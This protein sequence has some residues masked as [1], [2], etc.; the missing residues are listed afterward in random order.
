[1]KYISTRGQMEP[2]HFKE[3][4]LTGLA[5]DG[6]LVL[7]MDLPDISE[8][9]DEWKKLSYT[10]LAYEVI[11]LFATDIPAEDLRELVDRSY[12]SFTH[13]DVTPSVSVGDLHILELFH[14][15]TLAFK[16]VALQLLGNLFSYILEERGGVLNILG[17]T[18]G[19]TGSAAIEGVRGKSNINIFMMYPAGRTSPI[20][21]KQMTSVLDKNVYNIALDGTFDD[22]QSIMK[23]LFADLPY[24]RQY[25][26]GA[27]NSVNWARVLAQMVYYFY[28]AFRVMDK[29]QSPS[30]R[31]AV[32]TGNFGD[33]LAGYLAKQMGLPISELLLATNE[34]DILTR[35]FS[36]GV[37]GKATV[38]PTISPSMDIQV[39]SNFERYL[40][41]RLNADAARVARLMEEFK[42][43]GQL[44][45]ATD[46][47]GVVDPLF[48]AIRGGTEETLEVIQRYQDQFNYLLDPHTALGV[49]AAES[50]RSSLPTICL[51]TAH[52][53]KFTETIERA[54]GNPADHPALAKIKEAPTRSHALP[55]EVDAVRAYVSAH[56]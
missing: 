34:N 18:S 16:D 14:G 11:S 15:P 21:E 17:A 35:F 53:A 7:P 32:P 31:F 44:S 43:Q 3:A 41:Y 13:P 37:Y 52:P 12:A 6:G 23:T 5:S 8:R 30:V 55:N 25:H 22:C 2:I 20:Q 1:M 28:A 40:F 47:H 50:A 45:I 10:Q 46:E 33:I 36:S 4:V 54:T 42:Q 49:Y 27:V 29:T 9:C 19:D 51:A 39:A 26:L 56:V 24:K 38:V 48:T